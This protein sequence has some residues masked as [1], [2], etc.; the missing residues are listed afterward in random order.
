MQFIMSLFSKQSVCSNFDSVNNPFQLIPLQP[1]VRKLGFAV[2]VIIG[3]I[4]FPFPLDIA[5][6]I[7]AAQPSHTEAAL[8]IRGILHSATCAKEMKNIE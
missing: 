2:K 4:S 8:H 6:L 7:P 3:L 1:A 5:P